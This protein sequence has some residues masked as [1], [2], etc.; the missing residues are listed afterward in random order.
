MEQQNTFYTPISYRKTLK[1]TLIGVSKP[2]AILFSRQKVMNCSSSIAP[3]KAIRMR[4]KPL[5]EYPN[6]VVYD[7]EQQKINFW[8]PIY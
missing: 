8:K 5:E 2:L 6:H 4:R 1:Q 3:F 7:I